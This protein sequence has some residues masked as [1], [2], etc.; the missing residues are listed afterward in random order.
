[1]R[2]AVH[3]ERPPEQVATA[4]AGGDADTSGDGLV[5]RT[6]GLV[7]LEPAAGGDRE[8]LARDVALFAVGP[9]RE[10]G[11]AI[12]RMV[13]PGW[14]MSGMQIGEPHRAA[15]DVRSLGMAYQAVD[16]GRGGGYQAYLGGLQNGDTEVIG[17]GLPDR[18]LPGTGAPITAVAGQSAFIA[19]GSATGDV[20]CWPTDAEHGP[21]AGP[22][23]SGAVTG[24]ATLGP[25]VVSSGEDGRIVLWAP[26]FGVEPVHEIAV[27]SAVV[28]LAAYGERVAARDAR[29]RLWLLD[30]DP[31]PGDRYRTPADY[32]LLALR[33]L[34]GVAR[35][36]CTAKD[37]DTVVL[38]LVPELPT[39]GVTPADF[40]P[41][42]IGVDPAWSVV[43]RTGVVS[44]PATY[45]GVTV[46]ARLVA[47]SPAIR[48]ARLQ[49]AALA[50]LSQHLHPTRGGP[51]GTGWPFGR[52]VDGA[53]LTDLLA[54]LPGCAAVD[55]Q[56]SPIPLTGGR[57]GPRTGRITLDQDT[58]P[59]LVNAQVTVAPP[60]R[61]ITTAG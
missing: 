13:S 1:V 21:T 15:A 5:Y 22:G 49:R 17:F 39:S 60:E 10:L 61:P 40:F 14:A 53:E 57:P 30:L 24:I 33:A 23:H 58:L 44:R 7:V 27:G 56:L 25:W 20:R 54:A 47:D 34:P 35:V 31:E 50:T 9:H 48:A 46:S 16:R 28:A 55:L 26:R 19:T 4:S 42:M 41:N 8:V 52:A 6:A 36:R 12:G 32:E 51:A 29:G 38:V 45:L 59:F 11:T 43:L 18:T 37:P 2:T 3:G